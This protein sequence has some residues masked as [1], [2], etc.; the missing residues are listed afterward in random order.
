MAT[1]PNQAGSST[2][3]RT[4]LTKERNWTFSNQSDYKSN[5]L[6]ISNAIFFMLLLSQNFYSKYQFIFT[7]RIRIIIA[8]LSE[9]LSYR[10]R[11]WKQISND[12]NFYAEALK[13]LSIYHQ[14]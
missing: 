3:V 9:T 6:Y 1:L 8:F 12:M 7:I 2:S 13:Y 4:P 5:Y 10:S 14:M 11:L